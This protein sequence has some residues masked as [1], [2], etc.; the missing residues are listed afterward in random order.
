[1]E[2]SLY[3]TGLMLAENLTFAKIDL[4]FDLIY[5]NNMRKINLKNVVWKEGKYYVAWNL[6]TAVSSFGDTR[7][8]AL[9][10]LQEALELSN[11]F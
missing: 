9:E 5:D 11:Q 4:F 8:E 2:F 7:K 1:M 6:N 10:S 3:S